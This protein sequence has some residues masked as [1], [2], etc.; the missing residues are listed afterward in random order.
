MAAGPWRVTTACRLQASCCRSSA[1][2]PWRMRPNPT[3]PNP[4][5]P[6]RRETNNEEALL[7][8]S[9]VTVRRF[10]R[11]RRRLVE[12]PLAAGTS[13]SPSAPERAS[14]CTSKRSLPP[15]SS[16]LIPPSS[17]ARYC[18]C[19]ILS[20]IEL[21]CLYAVDSGFMAFG[22]PEQE[23]NPSCQAHNTTGRRPLHT[24]MWR[25]EEVLREKPSFRVEC[26]IVVN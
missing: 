17:P 13:P 16:S 7:S 21:Y 20:R 3:Q 14:R 1:A 22:R 6:K 15:S 8:L 2:G 19:P 25:R 12:S 10:L 23:G 11:R 4:I 18:Y 5:Q 26:S 9:A 24:T